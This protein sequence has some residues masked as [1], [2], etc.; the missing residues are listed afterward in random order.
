RRLVQFWRRQ[1]GADVHLA[2]K[3]IPPEEYQPTSI[4]VS[5]IYRDDADECFITSV[6][7]IYLLEMI[8]DS[9]FSIEEKNRI[10]RNLEGFKPQT[11]VKSKPGK[12]I[13]SF[14]ALIMGFG[15]P[16]PRNIEKDLKVFPWKIIPTALE[17][18]IKKYV[19][20]VVFC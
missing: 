18:V 16:K 12:G 14:F 17:K 19:S 8:I 3:S 13:D 5:C 7:L 4:V 2:F 15:E 10:R 11:V 6:D 1:D 9:P 20:S